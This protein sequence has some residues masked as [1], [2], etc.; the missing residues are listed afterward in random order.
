MER[1]RGRERERERER[2]RNLYRFSLTK[3]G[4]YSQMTEY[5]E[6]YR[7]GSWLLK[8]TL[9]DPVSPTS[10]TITLLFKLS[11]TYFL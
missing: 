9:K 11:A 7:P 8:V 5:P 2:E 4:F 6:A 3:Q 1:D 10:N